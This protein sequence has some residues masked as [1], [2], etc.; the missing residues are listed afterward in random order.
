MKTKY[1]I[2][3]GCAALAGLLTGCQTVPPG[4]ERGPHGTVAYDILVEASEPGARIEANGEYVGNTPVHLKVF[5]DRDGTFHDFGNYDYVIQ[6]L[7]LATNQFAQV[8]AYGTGRGWTHADAIPQ[9]VYFDMN[10]KPPPEPPPTVA[11]RPPYP[12]PYPYPYYY[13]P[14]PYYYG[15]YWWGPRVVIGP[16]YWRWRHW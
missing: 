10:Q 7:P 12:Y 2:F 6:A 13:G 11:G 9:R 15:P 5:G 1:L 16:G 3:A 4:V 8:R 14:N